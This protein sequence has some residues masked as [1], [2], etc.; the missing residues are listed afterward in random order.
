MFVSV[1]RLVLDARDQVTAAKRYI[2]FY[3]FL[4]GFLIAMVTLLKGLKNTGMKLDFGMENSFLNAMPVG[5]AIGIVVALIGSALV[6]RVQ[7]AKT[8]HE[9]HIH[10]QRMCISTGKSLPTC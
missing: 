5:I 9:E 1:K 4:V 7:F 3:I 2:P 6:N 10:R 8:Q